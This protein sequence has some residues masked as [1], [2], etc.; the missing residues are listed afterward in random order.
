M[1][2]GL[3]VVKAAFGANRNGPEWW[4][5]KNWK[6]AIFGTSDTEILHTALFAMSG[7]N[8]DILSSLRTEVAAPTVSATEEPKV[9]LG[10]RQEAAK[11][12]STPLFGSDERS[13]W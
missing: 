13:I 6:D 7:M 4:N 2:T 10:V 9:P 1:Q 12:V 8:M 3:L 11:S 5:I